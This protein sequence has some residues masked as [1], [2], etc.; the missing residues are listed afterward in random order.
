[1]PENEWPVKPPERGDDRHNLEVA[2]SADLVLFMSMADLIAA[3]RRAHPEIKSIFYETLPSV[4]H[5]G[6]PRIIELLNILVQ[7]L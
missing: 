5:E 2:D 1:M 7:K 4:D 3:F 6:H